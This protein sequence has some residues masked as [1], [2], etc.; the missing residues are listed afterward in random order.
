MS[1]RFSRFCRR[2]SQARNSSAPRALPSES[3]G[4]TWRTCGKRSVARP[5][6]RCVGESGVISSRVGLLERP[7]LAH[8]VVVFVVAEGRVVELVVAVIG[9]GD[10]PPELGGALL[11][12]GRSS[13]RTRPSVGAELLEVPAREPLHLA[14]VGEVE[15]DRRDRDPAAGDGVEVGALLVLVRGLEAVDLVA[16]TPVVA[17]LDQLELVVVEPL[18]QTA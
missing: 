3:I 10:Q 18:A 6:T 13:A 4:S 17:L 7:Q 15:V 14:V 5:L 9:L 1:S 12:P 8:Q 2:V 16:A 11:R